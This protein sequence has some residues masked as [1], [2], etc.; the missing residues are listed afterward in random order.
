M[1]LFAVLGMDNV[2][3]RVL[4]PPLIISSSS[5]SIYQM[6]LIQQISFQLLRRPP[7][8]KQRELAF[9]YALGPRQTFNQ[10]QISPCLSQLSPLVQYGL[11]RVGGHS[12]F[13]CIFS[14][15][16][17]HRKDTFMYSICLKIVHF[18]LYVQLK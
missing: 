7:P 4:F 16:R 10:L 18:C 12:R 1:M 9:H 5:S 11:V 6:L 8:Q 17:A 3:P 2:R 13:V 14:V 15:V